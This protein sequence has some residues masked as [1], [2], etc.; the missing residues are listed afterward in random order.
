M[1]IFRYLINNRFLKLSFLF[2]AVFSLFFLKTVAFAKETPSF[3]SASLAAYNGKYLSGSDSDTPRPLASLTKLM[4]ALVLIDLDIDFNKKVK[5]EKKQIDYVNPYIDAGDV[6]SS[7]DLRSGDKVFL[8]DLWNAMLIASSN[9]AAAALV[10]NSGISRRDF[11]AR[12]NAKAKAWGLKK[13]K[14]TEM[15]GIDPANVGT[16]R[17]MA[18]I[19]WKAYRNPTIRLAGI[20]TRYSFKEINSGRSVSFSNRNS[21]LLAMEPI[22]MKVGYLTEAKNNV[23]IRLRSGAKDRVIVVLH[24]E[25]NQKRNAEI[26][27]LFK[28]K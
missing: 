14:F 28:L 13:T 27:R 10:D 3:S 5:I 24:A 11:V 21:S 1:K 6:T 26:S 19:A 8:R 4:T 16:A 7:I 23:A 12:M 18:Y 2:L 17:E 9:E 22:G 15:S 25:N 20:K